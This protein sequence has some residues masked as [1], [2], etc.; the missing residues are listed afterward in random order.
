MSVLITDVVTSSSQPCRCRVMIILVIQNNCCKSRIF[1][2]LFVFVYFIRGGFRTKI[3]CIRVGC[4]RLI[5]I[6]DQRLYE[7]LEVPNIRKFSAHEIFWIYSTAVTVLVKQ[8][9][10]SIYLYPFFLQRCL[11]PSHIS[12]L[13]PR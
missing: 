11:T 13:R 10:A 6:E 5:R 2:M 7:R 4:D 1:R 9:F 12:W 3:P 8:F